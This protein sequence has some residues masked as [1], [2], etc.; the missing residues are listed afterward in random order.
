MSLKFTKSTLRNPIMS[1]H[2]Q[3]DH[4]H[5]IVLSKAGRWLCGLALL[6]PIPAVAEQAVTYN[7]DVRP[8]LT[9]YCFACHGPDSGSREADLRLD[10]R[11]DAVDYGAI[12][13]G[14][15]DESLLI[16]RLV[17]DDPDLLMPPPET[18]KQ[19]SPEQIETLRRWIA[20][21][22]EYQDHWA[23]IP[24]TRPTPPPVENANWPKNPIDQ[25][26][27]ARL[28]S[29]GL[30]PAA[31]ADAHVLCRRLYLDLT[32]LPPQPDAV[33]EFVRH[34]EADK[35][36]AVKQFVDRLMATPEWGEHRARYWLDAAR[37]ADTHGIHF[38]NYREIWPYRDWTIRAFNRNQPFDQFTIEQLAGDLLPNPTEDQLVATGFQRCNPTTNEG[39][40]IEAENLANYAA[41]HVQTFSWVFLGLTVNCA[42]CHDHKFDP[43]SLRDYYAL[44]AYFRNTTAPAM[45]GNV[46]DGRGP[47]LTLPAEEDRPRWAAVN[48]QIAESRA[49]L[50]ELRKRAQEEFDTWL[51]SATSDA[52]EEA[53]S[54]ERLVLYL[55]LNEGTNSQV[56]DRS[57]QEDPVQPVGEITWE[58]DGLLG[59]APLFNG[60]QSVRVE[61]AGDFEKHQ[62]FSVSAW[63]KTRNPNQTASIVA[64][65]DVASD[66][67]GWD[68]WLSNGTLSV[69]A[70]DH[71]PV[72]ALKVTTDK[73]VIVADRWQHVL[74]TYDGTA[75]TEGIKIY[76]DGKLATHQIANNT[77][78][79]DASIRAQTPFHIAQRSTGAKLRQTSVQEVRLYDRL[80]GAEEI[81][82]LAKV[83]LLA[84]Y[85]ATPDAER[86]NE[87]RAM[88]LEAYLA[89]IDTGYRTTA[90]H[91]EELQAE[92]AAML[93]RG[94]ITHIQRE[95]PDSQ[96]MT[97]ILLRGEYD[98]L[99]EQVTAS[100]PEA[101][102]PM[103]DGAPL[104]RLGLA[105]WVIDSKNPLTSRV[106]VNRFWQELF[107]QGLVATAED[108]GVSGE[109]P[110]HPE[111]LDWLAVEFVESGWDV[112]HM[113]R[114][115]LTSATYRQAAVVTPKK[116]E[117]DPFNKLLSRGPR[118]RMDGEMVRDYALV[119]SG[120]LS[121]KRFGPGAKPYQPDEIWSIVGL[122]G[123]NTRDYV[124]DTGENLYRRTIY[125][126]W[127]R[128]APP[129]NIEAFNAPSREVCTVRRERTNT[130]LQA[131]VT[132]NDPQFVEAAR[133]LAEQALSQH[134]A[135]AEIVQ[136][137]AQR[138]LCRQLADEE[139][140]LVLASQ[141]QYSDYYQNHADDA[142]ALIKVGASA[143]ATSHSPAE[144]ATWTMVATELLNLDETLSK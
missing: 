2:R 141:Q 59:P 73:V 99:G 60:E 137:M 64:R 49:Q 62:P 76:V 114:L 3:N 134:Q 97:H 126:F 100:T 116:L 135:P 22:A 93:Q 101:L 95:R 29:E 117:V 84:Q 21:G 24:P 11:E 133:R 86:A 26:V 52:L 82:L 83:P 34:Y 23:F 10:L 120:L 94:A 56:A 9:E 113:Y 6:A 8:I 108:F 65:M 43:I 27:L 40:T 32:G 103:P 85:V 115:M 111:L 35:D 45:D 139:L 36:T 5:A 87:D 17:T 13:P 131:L 77:L 33:A 61:T 78:S 138:V 4:L 119:A 15:P 75:T 25:F 30:E 7:H 47:T 144:L 130:P 12:A 44:S 109:M 96:P 118:F 14:H 37:Y 16:E 28:A 80:L 54:P 112:Q 51:A 42:Q 67:R 142:Q 50:A 63:V 132:L 31:E 92:R 81:M 122:P 107:G 19:L 72:K 79:T 89:V 68:I 121:S 1:N 124:Q 88:A 90:A 106:T 128:M 38:D 123:G 20:G 69:H 143:P 58:A 127:K 74:V 102:H 66:H 53:T 70:I 41:D 48:E 105:Q 71:W 136:T 57:Q 129:P 18:K 140:A 55:P 125:S 110:T 46:K 39:G 104:N 91:L 98:N